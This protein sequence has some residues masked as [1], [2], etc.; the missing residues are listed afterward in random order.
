MKVAFVHIEKT[1][2]QTF[3]H[4]FRRRHAFSY[5]YARPILKNAGDFVDLKQF[6]Y[7]R[8]FNPFLQH[9]GG[10]SVSY[11]KFSSSHFVV[12]VMRDPVKRY[13]SN[14][15]YWRDSMGYEGSF[16]DF[17]EIKE[18]CNWQTQ[19][20]SNCYDV[21]LA[22]EI[23]S[24]HYGLVG[25]VENFDEFMCAF[26]VSF[27]GEDFDVGKVMYGRENS[28]KSTAEERN[29]LL[30]EYYNTIREKN[31][32]DLELYDWVVSEYWPL[33]VNQIREEQGINIEQT[34]NDLKSSLLGY[35]VSPKELFLDFV[36]GKVYNGCVA[37]GFRYLNDIPIKGSYGY[38]H[39]NIHEKAD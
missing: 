2:G 33:K 14:Y 6:G 16:D 38:G 30:A 22:K 27:Y 8:L 3:S 36:V 31:L 18:M 34:A 17:L 39:V 7:M 10:H 11:S 26:G 15:L 23:I 1:G 29:H 20:I 37:G 4:W 9:L 13:V 24:N 35:R 25:Y 21:G 32:L 28:S 19:K 12:A 5:W